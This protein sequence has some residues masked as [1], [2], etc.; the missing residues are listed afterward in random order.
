MGLAS[1]GNAHYMINLPNLNVWMLC[2]GNIHGAK[3]CG[4]NTSDC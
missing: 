2:G 1:S 4:D 3:P